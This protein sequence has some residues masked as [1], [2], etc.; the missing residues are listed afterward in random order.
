MYCPQKDLSIPAYYNAEK[1][2]MAMG[3]PGI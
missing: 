3:K 1:K 2:E